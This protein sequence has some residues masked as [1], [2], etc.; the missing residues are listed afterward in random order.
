MRVCGLKLVPWLPQL[1]H[2]VCGHNV[3]YPATGDHVHQV[4]VDKRC[5]EGFGERAHRQR[6]TEK[7]LQLSEE[8][9]LQTL[10][11]Q[12]FWQMSHHPSPI[13]EFGL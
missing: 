12:E 10:I 2:E 5:R 8:R 9:F 13:R 7:S 3:E 11:Q 4:H 1:L 6:R